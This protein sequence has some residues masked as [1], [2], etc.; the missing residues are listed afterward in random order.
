MNHSVFGLE[1]FLRLQQRSRPIIQMSLHRVPRGCA[2]LLCN[3]QKNEM[4]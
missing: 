1:L 4:P 3:G 2:A